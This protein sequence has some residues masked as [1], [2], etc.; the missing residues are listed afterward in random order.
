MKTKLIP[1]AGFFLLFSF[2]SCNSSNNGE[3]KEQEQEP[4]DETTSGNCNTKNLIKTIKYDD[5]V[6]DF[7]QEYVYA[8]YNSVYK[9][10]R[11]LFLNYPKSED[12]DSGTKV[13][14]QQRIVIGIFNPADDEFKPGKYTWEGDEKGLNKIAVQVETASGLKTCNIQGIENPGFVE[15]TDVSN[16]H[17]CG[18]FHVSGVGFELSGE[19]NTKHESVK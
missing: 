8:N 12:N 9:S 6:Q 18:K 15:I 7:K 10:Y 11:V 17:I 5:A 4:K 3:N 14:G 2:M 13:G 19:F 1:L 16:T